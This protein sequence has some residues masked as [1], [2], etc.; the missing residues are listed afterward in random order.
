MKT[1]M[2]YR[3]DLDSSKI[4]SEELFNLA[5]VKAHKYQDEY[6]PLSF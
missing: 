5:N 3:N 6:N 1:I 2:D 4:T